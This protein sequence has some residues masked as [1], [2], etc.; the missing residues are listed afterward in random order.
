MYVRLLG[1]AAGGGLPQWNCAC[2]N[3]AAARRREIPSRTQSSGAVSADGERWWLVN[4]SPDLREQL[5]GLPPPEGEMRG[6]P[7]AGVLVTNADLDHVLGLFLLREGRGLTIH[8]TEE[9]RQTL[10]EGLRMDGV[11]GPFSGVD[12]VVPPSEMAELAPG[13]RY[14]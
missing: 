14:R 5:R 2:I 7:V 11:L 9:V 1:A 8:A 10:A 12:W 6:T 13:L 3:C 4:A